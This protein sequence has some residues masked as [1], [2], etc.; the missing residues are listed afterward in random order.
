MQLEIA[1]KNSDTPLRLETLNDMHYA[2]K[3]WKL[4]NIMLIE[5][6]TLTKEKDIN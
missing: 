3:V 5:S 6:V 1:L 4:H 2:S